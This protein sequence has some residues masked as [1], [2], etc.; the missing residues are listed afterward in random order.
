MLRVFLVEDELIIRET[1]RDTVPWGQYGYTVVGEAGDG[2]L[3]LPL[4]RQSKPDVLITDIKMPFMDGLALSKLVLADFPKMKVIILSGYDEFE[5]AR[6]AIEIG[7]EQYLL[8]PITKNNLLD[9]LKN[10]RE[11]IE[12]EKVQNNYLAQFHIEAQEYEQYARRH[13]FERVVAGQLS[14][15]QIY[16]AAAKLDLD[17]HAECYTIAFFSTPPEYTSVTEGYSE[18]G[19]RIHDAL[20][21]HFLKFPEYI[22]LRWNL[23]TYAVMIKGE[24]ACFQDYIQRCIDTVRSQYE[25]CVPTLNWHVAVGTPTRRLSTLSACFEEVY[26]LWSYRLIVPAQHILMADTVDFLTGTGNDSN[27]DH[28][29]ASKVNPAILLGV[30]R[31]GSIEEIPSFVNQYIHSIA[32]ALESKP[33]CQYL[34]LSIRFTATEFVSSF[35]ASLDEFLVKLECLDLVGQNITESELKRYMQEILMAVVD[36]RDNTS[37][38]QYHGLLSQAVRFIDEFYTAE[39][40]SLNRVAKQIK[41]SPNYLSAVFSQEMGCTITEYITN[42]R[43]E[44]ARDLLRNTNKRSGEVAFEVGYRDSHY[45]SFIFKK[46]QGCTPRDYRSGRVQV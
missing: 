5:Y 19:A 29:D 35:G 33:F 42:K 13:F 23:T 21:E 6:Q 15:H 44:K 8:K 25:A 10:I 46:T 24:T 32:D 2:E 3:A 31:S 41:I 40:L 38:S 26:R 36:L 34:M 7:V 30:M 14:V 4:I 37:S 43:M 9:V 16:E 1:L 39:D 28:L 45:F 11:K 18:Q 27:L 12:S 20:L 17:L 22:L